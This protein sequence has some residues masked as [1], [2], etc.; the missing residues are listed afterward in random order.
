M[1]TSGRRLVLVLVVMVLHAILVLV[2][3]VLHLIL[4]L[5]VMVLHFILVLVVMVLQ[6]K[7]LHNNIIDRTS[8]QNWLRSDLWIQICR[9]GKS[10]FRSRF[11]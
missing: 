3:M 11:K 7:M 10:Q 6:E 5:V 2:V 1:F 9:D 4:V 8:R